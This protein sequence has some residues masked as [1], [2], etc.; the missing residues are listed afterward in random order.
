MYISL[1]KALLLL[2]LTKN[3]FTIKFT[4]FLMQEKYEKQK[5]KLKF[6]TYKSHRDSR[7]DIKLLL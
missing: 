5:I 3:N 2:F 4:F 6:L 1:L 7:S